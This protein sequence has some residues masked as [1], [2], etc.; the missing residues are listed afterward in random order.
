MNQEVQCTHTFIRGR[1]AGEKCCRFIESYCPTHLVLHGK[2][3][4][5]EVKEIILE[6][7][8]KNQ[9]LENTNKEV[10]NKIMELDFKILELR[11][12]IPNH[13][14][15]EDLCKQLNL[16][17]DHFKFNPDSSTQDVGILKEHF[18]SLKV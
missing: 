13:L 17:I 10:T 4:K 8:T 5:Y 14:R 7:E 15:N 3:I 1:H 2:R 12:V 9:E 6:L 16:L 11:N 18:E